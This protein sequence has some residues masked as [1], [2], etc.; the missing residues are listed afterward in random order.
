MADKFTANQVQGIFGEF[1][2]VLDDAV[3]GGNFSPNNTQGIFGL[4]RSVLDEVA[5]A[6]VGIAAR[7]PLLRVGR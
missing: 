3:S 5:G 6:A 2:P 7:L 1:K 4:F